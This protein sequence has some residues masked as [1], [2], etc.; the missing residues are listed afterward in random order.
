MLYRSI[1]T[2]KEFWAISSFEYRILKYVRDSN[3]NS[4]KFIE[5]TNINDSVVLESLSLTVSLNE[6]YDEVSFV[7]PTV[8]V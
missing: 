8:G 3:D 5:T 4:W 7:E 1:P 6:I 2:L